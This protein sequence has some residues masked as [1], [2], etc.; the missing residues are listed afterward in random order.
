MLPKFLIADNSQELP[1]QIF[2][3]HTEFP[4]FIVGSDVEDFESNQ[5][6]HWIDEKP[7]DENLVADLLVEAESFLNNELDNQD[8]LFD[9]DDE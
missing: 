6:I 2:V 9:E 1:D 7:S 4:R 5:E 3:V 8:E